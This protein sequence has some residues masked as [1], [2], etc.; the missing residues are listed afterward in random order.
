MQKSFLLF[1]VV[2]FWAGCTAKPDANKVAVTQ[3]DVQELKQVNEQL[4]VGMDQVQKKIEEY[5]SIE[6]IPEGSTMDRI[7]KSR[8][9]EDYLKKQGDALNA[10]LETLLKEYAE[11]KITDKDYDTK[12][13]A[14]K[15]RIDD[16]QISIE[17][18]LERV[19]SAM[20]EN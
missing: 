8:S 4:S 12:Y 18:Y 9:K 2:I 11:G 19:K 5:G 13:Q 14:L 7:L 17:K 3:K 15:T 6:K 10:E 16:H 1:F 20:E